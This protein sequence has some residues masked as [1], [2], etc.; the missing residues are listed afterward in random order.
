M[1]ELLIETMYDPIGSGNPGGFSGRI[2]RT[3]QRHEFGAVSR[4][5]ARWA[6]PSQ[7]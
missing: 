2:D 3:S 5:H 7:E 1:I 6:V 4:D